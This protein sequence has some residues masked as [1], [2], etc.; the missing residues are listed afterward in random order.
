MTPLTGPD[1]AA[2]AAW[3]R[4]EREHRGWSRPVMARRLIDAAHIQ[5]DHS[6]PGLD[7]MKHNLYRW[8]RGADHPADH[9]RVLIYAVLGVPPPPP[10]APANGTTCTAPA[11]NGGAVPPSARRS[12]P[13]SRVPG[14][15][16][17]AS[18][19]CRPARVPPF[20]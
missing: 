8:E 12:C 11:V 9:Y 5:G 17:P 1:K 15:G 2:F 19:T 18:T 6:V 3:L 10:R 7:A 14:P 16:W 13:G 4:A 20:P